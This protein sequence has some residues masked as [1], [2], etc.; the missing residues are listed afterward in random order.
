MIILLN[1]Q[2][3]KTLNFILGILGVFW[4]TRDLCNN[5]M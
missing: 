3:L 1:Q 5:C 4:Y 2:C